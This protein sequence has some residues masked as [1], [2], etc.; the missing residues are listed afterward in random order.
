M[1]PVVSVIIPTFNRADLLPQAIDSVMAQTHPALEIIVIDDASTDDTADVMQRYS[2]SAGTSPRIRY[3]RN[4]R[5]AGI[6]KSRNRA[7]AESAGP[8]VAMLDSDDVWLDSTKIAMQ[9]ESLER[10]PHV[11]V[12]GTDASVIDRNGRTVGAIR[13]LGS[14]RGIRATLFIKNQFVTSSMLVRRSVLDETGG[15][16]EDIPI[17][18]DYELWLRIARRH[19]VANIRRRMT[20]YRIHDGNITRQNHRAFLDSFRI[21]HARYGSSFPLAWVLRVK[22]WRERLALSRLQA[23][24]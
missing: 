10:H 16:D 9:V 18:E 11:A 5:N 19:P 2:A 12:I 7:I 15:F 24:Q 17:M 3:L 8:Y 23:T 21:L 14:D 4:E 1:K 20:G 13:N 6:A 22:I